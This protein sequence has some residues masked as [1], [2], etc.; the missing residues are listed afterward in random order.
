MKYKEI[1][2][3]LTETAIWLLNIVS[4]L[5]VLVGGIIYHHTAAIYTGG[6]MWIAYCAI[7]TIQQR[8]CR[9]KVL[10][11]STLI[12]VLAVLLVIHYI[13]HRA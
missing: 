4:M 7:R 13:T 9:G 5:L 3:E 6:C 11:Y 2:A 8:H 1:K 10:T 12:A